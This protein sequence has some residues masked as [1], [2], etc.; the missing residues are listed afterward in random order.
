[1]LLAVDDPVRPVAHRAR[2]DAEVGA[3][4]GDEVLRTHLGLRHA[5]GEVEAVILQERGQEFLALRLVPDDVE[6]MN[7]LPGLVEGDG[8]AQIP[9]A[10]LL[11]HDAKRENV[12]PAAAYFL[13]DGERPQAQPAPGLEDVPGEPLGGVRNPLALA[14]VGPQFVPGVVVRQLLQF[15]LSFGEGEIHRSPLRL[16]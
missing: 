9:P 14:Y 13:G 15:E 10:D 5:D 1:M 3:F 16:K 4:F 11:A 6:E 12:G 8:H 7:D 2:A